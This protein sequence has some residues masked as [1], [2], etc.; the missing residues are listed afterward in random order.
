MTGGL[1]EELDRRWSL[2]RLGLPFPAGAST[3]SIRELR[4]LDLK[5]SSGEVMLPALALRR[6]AV[7]S[8]IALVQEY[9]SGHGALLAPHMKTTMTPRLI[10]LQLAAGAWGVS[11]ANVDQ[12]AIAIRAGARHVLIANE[13]AGSTDARWLAHATTTNRIDVLCLVDSP[14]G[15]S[16][17][18]DQLAAGGAAEPVRVL[19]E[20]GHPGG[21][22]GTRGMEDALATAVAVRRSDLLSL[23]GVSTYEGVV[24]HDSRPETLTLVD[25][26]LAAV[27]NIAVSLVARG[28]VDAERLIVS[29]GG[30]RYLDRVLA[31]LGP[32]T[33]APCHADLMVRPGSA[34]LYGIP[35]DDAGAA[36]TLGVAGRGLQ[37]ALHLWAQ[38]LSCPEHGLAIA[39]VGKRNVGDRKG[40][41]FPIQV[42]QPDG[43]RRAIDGLVS[44]LSL[45][46]Q[47][48]YLDTS[49]CS[50]A[51]GSLVQFAVAYPAT[52]D[53][54]RLVTVVDDEDTLI[55]AWE[56]AF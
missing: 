30:T 45:D 1:D 31:A 34:V 19:V 48:A 3:L 15:V 24:G 38:I 14:R 2:P 47:H 11:T 21:R 44:V 5:I 52:L 42:L 54:W 23:A 53:R 16:L 26:H 33:W 12:A 36:R 9:V 22:A 43:E 56:T 32:R 41:L 35:G 27:R 50:V 51:V 46:D 7:E 8:N 4:T 37:P 13:I 18:E 20:I 25:M 28:L 39:N 49:R 10:G 17:L 29:A 40:S 6:P 55:D